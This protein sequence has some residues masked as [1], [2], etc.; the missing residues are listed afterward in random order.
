MRQSFAGG[1]P[2]PK[3]YVAIVQRNR[4]ELCR[5]DLESLGYEA[6]VASQKE[7]HVYRNRHRREITRI[8]IPGIVFIHIAESQRLQLLKST[9]Y[10]Q[11]FMT[12]K[13]SLTLAS[14]RRPFAIIPDHQMDTLR[15]MLYNADAPVSFI[16]TPL[17]LGDPI[18][19]IRGNLQ[20]LEGTYLRD[21]NSTHILVSLDLLGSAAVT[22]SPLDIEKLK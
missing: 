9:P 8:V 7:T 1:V 15:F 18:R 2:T 17:Q 22:I 11:F 13:A 4:E 20:G 6:Y 10:I 14:G 21:A 19:V 12:D 16:D 3:W 5:K